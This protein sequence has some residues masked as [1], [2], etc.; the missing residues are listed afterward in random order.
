MAE[1]EVDDVEEAPAVPVP[2]LTIGPDG[3]IMLDPKSL[4]S[5]THY[6]LQLVRCATTIASSGVTNNCR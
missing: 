2:Q 4:V 1:Q 6:Q 5:E 3:Q